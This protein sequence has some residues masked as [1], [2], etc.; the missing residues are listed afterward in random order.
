MICLWSVKENA[1]LALLPP[2]QV[3]ITLE[4][5]FSVH[6]PVKKNVY[7]YNYNDPS[8]YV[9]LIKKGTV[10]LIRLGNNGKQITL[11]VL[12]KGMIFGE[13]DVLNEATYTHYAETMEPCNICYIHKKDFKGLLDKYDSI[14]KMILN[15][16]YKHLKESQQKIEEIAFYDVRTRLIRNLYELSE[17]YGKPY[18]NNNEICTLIDLKISQDDLA[19]F[20]ATSRESVNRIIKDFKDE[21]ILDFSGRKMILTKDFYNEYKNASR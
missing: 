10:K 6:Q 3:D 13:G 18:N 11:S 19:D 5:L 1:I 21:G 17:T 20:V 2:D 4:K 16:M 8:E 14:N 15:I 7:I 9:Y 12:N